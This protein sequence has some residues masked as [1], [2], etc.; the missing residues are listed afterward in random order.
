MQGLFRLKNRLDGGDADI[1]VRFGPSRSGWLPL[2][3]DWDG[4]GKDGIGLF[5][6]ATSVFRLKSDFG[7][8]PAEWEVQHGP[9]AAGRVP[10]CGEW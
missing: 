10:L 9:P 2:A 6:P 1:L 5:A 4:D 8:G 3:G 7:L